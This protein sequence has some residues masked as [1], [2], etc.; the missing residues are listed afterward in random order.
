MTHDQRPA[1]TVKNASAILEKTNIFMQKKG[2][3]GVRLLTQLMKVSLAITA[4]DFRS[5]AMHTQHTSTKRVRTVH[6]IEW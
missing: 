2:G 4:L 3:K 6:R 1:Q 5:S